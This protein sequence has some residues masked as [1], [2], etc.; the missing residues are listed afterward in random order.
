MASKQSFLLRSLFTAILL[1]SLGAIAQQKN[2]KVFVTLFPAGDFVANTGDVKGSAQL[3]GPNE[4]KA[5]NIVV[6]LNSLKTGIELRDDH[7]KNKYLDVKQHP[8][9][10]LVSAEGKNGTGSGVL[11]IRGKESKVQGTYVLTNGNKFMTAKFK[12]KLSSY[13]INEVSY[14][15]IGAEDDINIEVTVPIEPAKVAAAKTAAAPDKPT[16]AP[17]SVPAKAVK[18]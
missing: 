15:G 6:N 10:V 11:K 13:G 17:A 16:K 9:A 7:A 18:K 4:V 1:F 3:V 5:S 8:E 14:K 12:T 2:V